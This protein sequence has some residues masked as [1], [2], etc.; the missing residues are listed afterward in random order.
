MKSL[1]RLLLVLI[2]LWAIATLVL[3]KVGRL[4]F[5]WTPPQQ[6]AAMGKNNFTLKDA[7]YG[8]YKGVVDRV[9]DGDTIYVKLDLGFD[10]TMY[11]RVRV[12]GINAPEN[13]TAAG[14]EATKFA[15]T[16]LAVGAEVQVTSHGWDKYGGRVDGEIHLT[17]AVKV[18]DE[19]LDD[20]GKIMLNSGHAVPYA[21]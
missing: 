20:F 11:A 16:I 6:T 21:G 7:V 9:Q 19:L 5:R 3:L 18:H 14:Q 13:S 1:C 17:E 8:P 2:V 4:Q 15:R 10:L 12:L